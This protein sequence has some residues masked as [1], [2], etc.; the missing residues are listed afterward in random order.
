MIEYS[1]KY[2]INLSL[3]IIINDK[4]MWSNHQLLLNPLVVVLKFLIVLLF[5]S[6]LEF[7]N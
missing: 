6:N 7:L 1:M 5:L 2:S 3:I 4:N